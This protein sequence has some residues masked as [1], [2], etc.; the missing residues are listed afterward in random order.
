MARFAPS[1]KY[2]ILFAGLSG[3]DGATGLDAERCEA[4]QPAPLRLDLGQVL[5]ELG[6]TED[7]R[8]GTAHQGPLGCVESRSP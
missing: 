2:G 1:G 6:R 3:S 7:V 4:V 5:S 8:R